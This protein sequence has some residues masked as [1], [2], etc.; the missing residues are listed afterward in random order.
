MSSC[1]PNICYL[2]QANKQVEKA[3]EIERTRHISADRNAFNEQFKSI[4]IK[5]NRFLFNSMELLAPN[6]NIIDVEFRRR[7]KNDFNIK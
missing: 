6:V 7:E 1:L 3:I 2:I 5:E 4:K